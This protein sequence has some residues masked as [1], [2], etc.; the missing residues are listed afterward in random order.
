MAALNMYVQAASALQPAPPAVG[1]LEH[2]SVPVLGKDIAQ[3]HALHAK[4]PCSVCMRVVAPSAG[5]PD[6]RNPQ[7][8]SC[9][10]RSQQLRAEVTSLTDAMLLRM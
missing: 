5:M 7:R 10:C 1:H 2:P 8:H 4:Q 6:S 3:V 9:L